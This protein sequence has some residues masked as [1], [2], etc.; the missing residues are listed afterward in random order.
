MKKTI[1]LS[2]LSAFAIGGVQA[3]DV[4]IDASISY[5]D[6][7]FS[8][9]N[10]LQKEIWS[11]AE[12][13][14]QESKSSKALKEHLKANGFTIQ[15]GI[16]GEPTAFIASYGSG[17]PIIGITAEFDALPGLSQDTVPYRKILRENGPGHGCGHN[18]FGVASSAAGVAISKWLKATNHSGTIRIYGSPAEEGGSGKT[19]IVRDGFYKDVDVVLDWHPGGENAVRTQP[20]LA[21]VGIEYR[22]Y[23]H[24][25]H[26]AGNPWNGRSALD[27][28]E[29]LDITTN[30]MREHIKPHNRIHYVIPNGGGAPN[31]VPSYARVEYYMRSP[32][33]KEL[34]EIVNWI[35]SAAY[36]AAL[37]T[38]TKVEKY[39]VA[40]QYEFLI[41]HTIAKQLQ[42]SLEKVGGIQWNARELEFAKKLNQHNGNP[43]SIL[44]KVSRVEPLGVILKQSEGGGSTDVADISWNVP[45][46]S[47]GT[48]TTVPGNPGHSWENTATVGTTIGTKGLINAA[49]VFTYT[50]IDLFQQ[51]EIIKTAKE[52]F[53]KARPKGFVYEPLAGDLPPRLDY[54]KDRN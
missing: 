13:G 22:F 40:G 46:A 27:A 34:K 8:T 33:V 24:S 7:N 16:A 28:V 17:K 4:N 2:L 9:Y 20:G 50:A 41:N 14:Y 12:V 10:K 15:E 18:L 49:K 23:G 25:A 38:Q 32:N 1:V 30:Y 5:L 54:R 48:V 44:D 29:I 6:Q 26:A 45:T 39:F 19:Y 3:Q 37:G 53:E 11:N 51:P 21:K 42:K 35:D 52:E 43:D 31:V 47:F 36:G